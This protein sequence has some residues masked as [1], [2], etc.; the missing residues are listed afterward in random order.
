ME[1]INK[2]ILNEI[3]KL[4]I[5]EEKEL[6]N[7][8]IN[9]AEKFNTNKINNK[10]YYKS[11]DKTLQGKFKNDFLNK[12][13][14]KLVKNK[15]DFND[16]NDFFTDNYANTDDY[17]VEL[18]T[19]KNT[20]LY[21]KTFGTYLTLGSKND[22]INVITEDEDRITNSPLLKR[23][24][25]LNIR[26]FNN[27]EINKIKEI[28]ISLENS[29]PKKNQEKYSKSIFNTDVSKEKSP[30]EKSERNFDRIYDEYI[31][32]PKNIIGKLEASKVPIDDFFKPHNKEFLNNFNVTKKLRY[33]FD[34]LV[35]KI[36]N[37]VAIN[38]FPLNKYL[39]NYE[40][41]PKIYPN[42]DLNLNFI[43]MD[44]KKNIKRQSLMKLLEN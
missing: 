23:T 29:S 41:N 5:E 19:L 4:N 31:R 18:E 26:N 32:L 10:K 3:K 7:E 42:A 8:Q 36:S 2:M 24:N 17:S 35:S 25:S 6:Q 22:Y 20:P 30:K 34:S 39:N 15:N 44:K 21:K 37:K 27:E 16:F 40:E 43:E 28:N 38:G 12:I 11:Y 1:K 14:S 33:K 13:F 9:N